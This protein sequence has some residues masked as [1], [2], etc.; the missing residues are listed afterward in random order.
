MY[1]YNVFHEKICFDHNLVRRTGHLHSYGTRSGSLDFFV[2]P[3]ATSMRH[4]FVV[5]SGIMSW[6]NLDSF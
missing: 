5:H 6:N 4:K 2:L 1:N 3:L